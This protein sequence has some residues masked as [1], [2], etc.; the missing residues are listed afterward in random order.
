MV[1]ALKAQDVKG[2]TSRRL[3]QDTG[4]C[5]QFKGVER[6]TMLAVLL[7]MKE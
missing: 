7:E 4:V 1:K 2:V 5:M 6:V 3:P